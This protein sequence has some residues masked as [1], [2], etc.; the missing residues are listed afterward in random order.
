MQLVF[1]LQGAS[2]PCALFTLKREITSKKA[3]KW[4]KR[5]TKQTKEEPKKAVSEHDEVLFKLPNVSCC[6]GQGPGRLLIAGGG[7]LCK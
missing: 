2:W 6:L 4:H 7:E 5:G 3:Q 1:S